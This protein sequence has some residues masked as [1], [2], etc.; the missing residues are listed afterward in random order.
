MIR[1]EWSGN[2]TKNY[3]ERDEEFRRGG[4]GA[5]CD[6]FLWGRKRV[7][8]GSF[9]GENLSGGVEEKTTRGEVGKM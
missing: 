6:F 2:N 5:L 8:A 3:M 4:G 7:S 9:G 1:G